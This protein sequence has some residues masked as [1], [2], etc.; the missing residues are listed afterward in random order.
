MRL[1]MESCSC[2]QDVNEIR[3]SGWS[4]CP[5]RTVPSA[6]TTERHNRFKNIDTVLLTV[7][8]VWLVA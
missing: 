8:C 1:G 4:D 6:V 2:C 5:V 7:D 3:C